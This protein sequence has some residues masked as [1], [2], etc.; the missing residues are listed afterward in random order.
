[1]FKTIKKYIKLIDNI[2]YSSLDHLSS[3]RNILILVT[4]VFC[5]KALKTNNAAVVATVFGCWTMIIGFYFHYREKEG[6]SFHKLTTEEKQEVDP[7]EEDIKNGK[8]F[9]AE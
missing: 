5:F 7:V 9:G 2:V 3:W 4:I 1:M 6:G 8:D